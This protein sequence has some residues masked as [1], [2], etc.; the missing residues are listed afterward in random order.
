MSGRIAARLSRLREA[1][2]PDHGQV[3]GGDPPLRL[4]ILGDSSA[5]GVGARS[6]DQALAGHLATDLARLTG[7]R[8]AWRVVAQTGATVR[9]AA[10]DL[11][12]RLADPAQPW[13]PDAVVVVAGVNDLTRLRPGPAWRQ[14]VAGLVAAIRG[15]LGGRPTMLLAGV[16]PVHR[17]PAL[18]WVVRWPQGAHAW[19]LDRQLARLA[20]DEPDCHHLPVRHLRV[21]PT[22]FF[23]P[24]RFH[25]AP[26]GYRAWALALASQAA[27]LLRPPATTAAPVVVFDFDGVLIR[28]D[29]YAHLVRQALQRSWWRLVAMLPVLAAAMPMLKLPALRR[30]GQ[31]LLVRLAFVGWSTAQFNARAAELGRRLARDQQVV[32]GD[33]VAAARRHRSLGARVVV[34]TASAQPL[35]R[36]VLDE[37][38][39]SSVGLIASQPTCGRLGLR[40]PMRNHGA[41]KVR[42]LA[43]HG[44]VPPWQ[45]AYSDSRSDLPM[46]H[47]ARRPILVNPDARLLARAR[48]KLGQRI[49]SVA[50]R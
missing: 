38:G 8:V 47:G 7:R 12:P 26:A 13:T 40:A 10:R 11:V 29:S 9:E 48:R 22:D 39:L 5:A 24:D 19:W 49:S 23:A 14:D 15:R 50:W 43:A 46:L 3:P 30:C 37:L 41:E 45:I 16:P 21:A 6:H 28:G 31:R 42:R 4:A 17:F 1:D 34:V 18:P 32:V 20:R 33:A 25:P 36:A 44:L 27:P 2:G 35:A